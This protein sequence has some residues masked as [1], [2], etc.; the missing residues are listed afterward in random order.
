MQNVRTSKIKSHNDNKTPYHSSNEYCTPLAMKQ[1]ANRLQK[2]NSATTEE[3]NKSSYS[4]STYYSNLPKTEKRSDFGT[5]MFHDDE[6][7]VDELIKQQQ[8]LLELQNSVQKSLQMIQ[9]KLKQGKNHENNKAGKTDRW[10]KSIKNSASFVRTNSNNLTRTSSTAIHNSSTKTPEKVDK[11][12]IQGRNKSKVWV[13]M[14]D[15]KTRGVG[16]SNLTKQP[17]FVD[18]SEIINDWGSQFTRVITTPNKVDGRNSSFNR[19]DWSS[20]RTRAMRSSWTSKE[21]TKSNNVTPSKI[22]NYDSRWVDK[23]RESQS[24][25]SYHPKPTKRSHT[26]MMTGK[27]IKDMTKRNNIIVWGK[28]TAKDSCVDPPSTNVF[29]N[30]RLKLLKSSRGVN[31]KHLNNLCARST[32]EI[33]KIMQ[34]FMLL[35]NALKKEDY[36]MQP[37][38]YSNWTNLWDQVTKQNWVIL[39]ETLAVA[40][41]I[42][43]GLYDEDLMQDICQQFEEVDMN[44]NM[45]TSFKTISCFVENSVLFYKS[46]CKPNLYDK[47]KNNKRNSTN[48]RPSKSNYEAIKLLP[49]NGN[50]TSLYQFNTNV[51]SY[52]K[53]RDASCNEKSNE[54]NTIKMKPAKTI[55]IKPNELNKSVNIQRRTS[56]KSMMR[57]SH[58]TFN[59]ENDLGQDR[60]FGVNFTHNIEQMNSQKLSKPLGTVKAT[61]TRINPKQAQNNNLEDKEVK[62]I[63]VSPIKRVEGQNFKQIPLL[64]IEKIQRLMTEDNC[65]TDNKSDYDTPKGFLNSMD[66]DWVLFDSAKRY[67]SEYEQQLSVKPEKFIKQDDYSESDSE[68]CSLRI[69]LKM[70]DA[71]SNSSSAM[72]PRIM[73]EQEKQEIFGEIRI[74]GEIDF[75]ASM[76]RSRLSPEQIERVKEITNYRR[77]EIEAT[78][79][80]INVISK[81]IDT[82]KYQESSIIDFDRD[83]RRKQIIERLEN[84]L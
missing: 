21:P 56:N 46:K 61:A 36:R 71:A 72:T 75:S 27:R 37:K 11:E 84:L 73:M 14:S 25:I 54:K 20:R 78:P 8:E 31:L 50:N 35:L 3:W 40:N 10:K 32:P 30:L 62:S 83:E 48:H 6:L 65:Y 33:R 1:H 42:E 41:K 77:K 70:W 82:E 74:N 44:K 5:N 13:G 16:K 80:A 66:G 38:V 69:E 18:Y 63:E 52:V 26:P 28:M 58:S 23:A 29:E 60:L 22:D 17:G 59:N 55:D 79:E 34:L 43:R 57:K 24:Y 4:T 45:E 2:F 81:L 64:Q 67:Q 76:C 9:K 39:S 53:N 15:Y 49:Q 68:S 7:P 51:S 19:K 47:I 12:P